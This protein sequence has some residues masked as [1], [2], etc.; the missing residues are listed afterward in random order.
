MEKGNLRLGCLVMAAGNGARFGGNKLA[1]QV[2]GKSLICRALDAV[3]AGFFHQVTVVTQYEAVA[4]LARERGFAVLE[5]PHPDWGISHTICLGTRAMKDCDGILYLVADQP[6]LRRDSVERVT[7][8]W[9]RT[10]DRIVGAGHQGRRG[11]PNLFPKALFPELLA[12][13]GDKG[14]S[15]VIKQHSDLLT[16]VE[17]A[18]EELTDCDTKG[19]L[20]QLRNREI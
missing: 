14:G 15:A 8:A 17:V 16:L 3:P 9:K 1:A 11:N 4:E 12:L 13:T 5:N 18:E 2:E 7:A 10:P 20:R 19:E 6:L